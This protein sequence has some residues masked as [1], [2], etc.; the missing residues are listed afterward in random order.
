MMATKKESAAGPD[1]IPFCIKRS[2]GGLESRFLLHAYKRVLEGGAVPAH[3][4]ASRTVLIPNSS[5]VDD[6]GL[7]VRSLEA[8]RPLTL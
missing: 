2:A 5:D 3:F 8:L 4:A 7:T 6:N 1:G